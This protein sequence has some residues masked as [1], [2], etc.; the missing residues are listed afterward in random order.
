MKILIDFLRANPV[1][2]LILLVL[3]VFVFLSIVKK[4]F[5][6]ALIIALIFLISGGALFH[7]SHLEFAKKGKELLQ[8]AEKTV[9]TKVRKYLPGFD[10]TKADTLHR[11]VSVK[12]RHLRR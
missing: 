4:L 8:S 12:K 7:I 1:I 11:K 6:L 3:L 10:S 5:K 2:G 9:S